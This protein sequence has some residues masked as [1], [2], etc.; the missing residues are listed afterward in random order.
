MNAENSCAASACHPA[1]CCRN[2]SLSMDLPQFKSFSAGIAAKQVS[3]ENIQL[4][5]TMDG[6][7]GKD[8]AVYYN[9]ID[10]P[11]G[12]QIYVHIR[13]ACPHLDTKTSDCLVYGKPALPN[14]CSN[15]VIRSR[16]CTAAR[17]R[18]GLSPVG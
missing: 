9:D 3:F 10:T 16:E 8:S 11:K 15:L 12:T 1:A 18:Q 4:M 7:G 5:Q 17:T 2:V 13:N 6:I 14:A